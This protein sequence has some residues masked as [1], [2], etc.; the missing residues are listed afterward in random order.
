MKTHLQISRSPVKFSRQNHAFTLVELLTVIVIIGILAGI[1]VPVIGMV[2]DR[3]RATVCQSNLRQ[4]YTALMMYVDENKGWLPPG[5]D[6][7]GG[8]TIPQ[9]ADYT[10]GGTNNMALHLAPY[11]GCPPPNPWNS[12]VNP[13][14]FCPGQSARPAN[15]N[16]HAGY[17]TYGILTGWQKGENYPFGYL[18]SIR[19]KRLADYLGTWESKNPW[20]LR[21][22]DR[23]MTVYESLSDIVSGRSHKKGHNY[24]FFNGRVRLLDTAQEKE[25]NENL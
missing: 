16:Y 14:F 9:H 18:G 4:I 7:T 8:L 1:L 12:R 21:D 15:L 22:I 5:P 19:P 11:M 24:L 17:R 13:F 2:R 3:T 25:L 20:V 6:S 23:E 10:S